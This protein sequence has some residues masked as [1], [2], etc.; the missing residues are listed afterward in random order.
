MARGF[1]K[2]NR[3]FPEEKEGNIKEANRKLRAEI[4][5]LKKII[6]ILENENK[7]LSRSFNKS[8]E[9]IQDVVKEKELED[10]F[11]MVDDFDY[12]ET[13]KGRDKEKSKKNNQKGDKSCPKCDNGSC[14]ELNFGKF[15]IYTCKCGFR[16]KVM[17]TDEGIERS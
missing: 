8:C 9:Y 5:N 14:K 16:E 15:K 7:T 2:F 4:R 10:I 6:K 3:A 13:S 1:R 11:D 12:K 17:T